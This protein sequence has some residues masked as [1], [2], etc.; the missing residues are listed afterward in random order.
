MLSSSGPL[1]SVDPIADVEE[2]DPD[3]VEEAVEE[4][5]AEPPVMLLNLVRALPDDRFGI[6]ETNTY[7]PSKTY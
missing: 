5:L 1:P 6:S 4:Y 2:I 3:V 7:L